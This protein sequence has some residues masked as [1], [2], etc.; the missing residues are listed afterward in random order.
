MLKIANGEN[1]NASES[2]SF[3][4]ALEKK[5][6]YVAKYYHRIFT[7]LSVTT[8]SRVK[9]VPRVNIDIPRQP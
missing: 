5:A 2:K 7:D 1:F 8:D 6:I 3:S 4:Q 9:T